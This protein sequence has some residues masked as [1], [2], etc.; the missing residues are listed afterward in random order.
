MPTNLELA[1]SGYAAL[2]SRDLEGFLALTT[3]DVEFR[4]LIAEM[5]GERFYGHDGVRR[6]WEGIVASLGGVRFELLEARDLTDDT[7]LLHSRVQGEVDG[8]PIEQQMWQVVRLRDGR[9][10]WWGTFRSEAE[11]LGAG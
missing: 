8:V 11:A 4:S 9:A 1:R 10:C 5:E 6:W 2:N 3:P 7:V